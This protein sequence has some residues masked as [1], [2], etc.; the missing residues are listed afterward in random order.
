MLAIGRALM[1]SPRCL[2]LDEPFEGLA[3]VIVDLL[4]EALANLRRSSSM[5]IVLVEQHAK[6][7]LDIADYGILIE[8]GKIRTAGSREDLYARWAEI[9]D[10]L[11]VTH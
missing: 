4:L 8:R 3:P 9:E 10:M 5:T 6:L 11:A 2:L 7:A 1:G